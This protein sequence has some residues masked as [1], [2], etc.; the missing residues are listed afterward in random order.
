M[1]K[2]LIARGLESVRNELELI[3]TRSH[4]NAL[5]GEQPIA[6]QVAISSRPNVKAISNLLSKF[7]GNENTFE[8]WKKQ[9]ISLRATYNLDDK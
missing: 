7:S 8:N 9:L 3:R 6:M 5:P 1:E 4:Q 2:E